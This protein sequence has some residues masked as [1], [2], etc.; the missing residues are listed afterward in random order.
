MRSIRIAQERLIAHREDQVTALYKRVAR[1][2]RRKI[3][4]GV[5][6]PNEDSQTTEN[7][8]GEMR[9]Q[10]KGTQVIAGTNDLGSQGD[11]DAGKMM[12]EVLTQSLVRIGRSRWTKVR[13]GGQGRLS[14]NR[15]QVGPAF[16][17][18]RDSCFRTKLKGLAV[19]WI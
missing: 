16:L 8:A 15:I 18:N 1:R 5:S 11:K 10:G 3:T 6:Q 4:S 19:R 12:E 14:Y 13:T 2:K 7:D 9:H 17:L